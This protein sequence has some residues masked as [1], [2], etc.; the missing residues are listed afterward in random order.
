[1]ID[2]TPQR[3]R[4]RGFVGGAKILARLDELLIQLKDGG[5]FLG[6]IRELAKRK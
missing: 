4:H 2:F 5:E 1:L 6:W 3:E